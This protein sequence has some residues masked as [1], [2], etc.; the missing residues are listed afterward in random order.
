[1][2]KEEAAKLGAKA[3]QKPAPVNQPEKAAESRKV[4]A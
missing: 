4:R 2:T 3:P 1:M